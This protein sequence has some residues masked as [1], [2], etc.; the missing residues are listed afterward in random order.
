MKCYKIEIDPT[1]KQR[2]LMHK[3]FGVCRFVYNLYLSENKKRYDGG[4]KFFSGYD[5]SKWL[6]N[7]FIPNNP[8]Y[9]W[10]KEVGSKAVKKSIM[11]AETAY[12]KFFK[13]ESKHPRYYFLLK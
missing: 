3:H 8:S 1:K 2:E 7:D 11:D 4:D 5:C 6:N 12:R 13:G 9:S 10:I